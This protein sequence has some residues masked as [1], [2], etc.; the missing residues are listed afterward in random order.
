MSGSGR[1]ALGQ[2]ADLGGLDRQ[3]AGLGLEQGAHDAEDVAQVPAL[4]GGVDFFADLVAGDVELDAAGD[5]LQRGEAGLAHDA[6]EH[7]AAGDLD[8][9]RQAF[10]FFGGFLAVAFVQ[11]GGGV[12][13]LEIVR[14]GLARLAPFGELGTALG[15]DVVFVLLDG[16]F[17]VVGLGHEES[18]K[19]GFAAVDR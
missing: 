15:D 6:L 3:L 18:L 4:E 16:L 11:L 13:A 19:M 14:E 7:H 8:F 9:D 1:S 12:L 10:Q 2:Q 17:G 5:V